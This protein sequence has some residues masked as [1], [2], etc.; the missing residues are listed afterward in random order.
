ME[1]LA[2]RS[3]VNPRLGSTNAWKIITRCAGAAAIPAYAAFT[4]VSALH[5]PLLSPITNWLSDYGNPILNPSGATWYNAGC[6]VTAA[7]LALFYIGLSQWH[8]GRRVERKYVICYII[9]QITGLIAAACLVV[10]SAVPLGVND[11]VH[12]AFSMCNMIGLNCFMSFTAIAFFLHPQ[13]PKILAVFGYA[14]AVFNI[15]AQNAFKEFFVAEWIYFLLFMVY[16]V[17]VTARYERLARY[18]AKA[19]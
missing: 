5:A 17:A 4:L 19:V 3:D 2:F 16:I 15:I 9:A 7:L 11:A 12:S 10:A 8:S 13:M 14:V 18:E 1:K 6:M